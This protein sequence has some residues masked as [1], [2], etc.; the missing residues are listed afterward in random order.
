MQD[1]DL[2]IQKIYGEGYFKDRNTGSDPKREQSYKI[3]I[4]K[5]NKYK[6]SGKV[7]DV[8]C[9]MGNFLELFDSNKWEKFGVEISDYARDIAQK[10]GIRFIDYD[11]ESGFFDLIIFR[12]VIQHLDTPL[13]VIKQCIRMLK[14]DGYIVFLAT[15]NINAIHYKMFNELPMLDSNCNFMLP[16]DIMMKQILNNF[17]M[18]IVEL[19]Y[20]YLE[21]PYKR[22]ISDHLKFALRFF[23]YKSKFAFWGNM[24]EI[25]CRKKSN[26][27]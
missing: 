21:S 15:P 22:I 24:M 4:N 16:S 19:N 27:K 17:G 8:G 18:E 6:S 25:T 7:L 12:G 10:K 1:S 20:P 11:F 26:A 5:I 3:E 2:E 14:E 13:F 23:G 9:G